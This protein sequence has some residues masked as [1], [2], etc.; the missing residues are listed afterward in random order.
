MS[1]KPIEGSK[2]QTEPKSSARR[3]L[4]DSDLDGVSGG[5]QSAFSNV[6]K[7]FGEALATAARKS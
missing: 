3:V 5:L 2:S 7:T 6:L 1:E 4:G